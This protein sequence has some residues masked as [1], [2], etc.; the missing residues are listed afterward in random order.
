MHLARTAKGREARVL[1]CKLSPLFSAFGV[2]FAL[3]LFPGYGYLTLALLASVIV[4]LGAVIAFVV[5]APFIGLLR[6]IA[7]DFN[8]VVLWRG[9]REGRRDES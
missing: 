6:V 4:L 3:Q 5:P 7:A 1:A 9:R 2:V 8:K